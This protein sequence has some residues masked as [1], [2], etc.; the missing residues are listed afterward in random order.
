[1]IGSLPAKTISLSHTRRV[2]L[3]LDAAR[4]V[5]DEAAAFGAK[6]VLLIANRSLVHGTPVVYQ[7]EHALCSAH[8]ATW[9]GVSPH[10]PRA[11]VLAGIAQARACGADMIVAIGGGSV[12]DA[13][14][15]INLGLQHEFT[16]PEDFDRFALIVRRKDGWLKPAFAAPSRP[17]VCVPTTLSGGEFSALA[18]VTDE[19]TQK[20]DGILHAEMAPTA[21]VLDPRVTL[22]T[23]QWLWLSTGIRSV[24]HAA[25]TLASDQSDPYSDG[26]AESAL[27]LLAEGLRRTHQDPSDL[28]ARVLCQVGTWQSKIPSAA[29]VPM[30]ASHA[31]GHVLGARHAVP[32]GYTSC[33]MAPWVQAWNASHAHERQRGISR[34]LGDAA[35]PAAELLAA[36]IRDLGLPQRLFEVGVH[37]QDLHAI[38]EATL[39][40]MWAATNPKPLAN[41]DDVMEILQ[42][43][44]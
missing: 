4:A 34:A 27:R 3:G 41:A 23:P 1:M 15:L 42:A 5:A 40:D 20:K 6:R 44:A 21:I 18:G 30:G 26:M 8:A 28:P 29:G 16:S 24:D 12:I 31:I 9:S 13:A 7:I 32:H 39:H 22:H 10:V 36:L 33:V 38:A 14:K 2:H 43:A 17:L 11:D 25:E 35:R 19:R 37:A